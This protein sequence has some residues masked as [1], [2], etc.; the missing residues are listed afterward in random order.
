[1]HAQ[2]EPP[3]YE[4]LPDDLHGHPYV[5]LSAAQ[6]DVVVDYENLR[7]LAGQLPL[8]VPQRRVAAALGHPPEGV[9]HALQRTNGVGYLWATEFENVHQTWRY[10]E[11]SIE[12]DGETYDCVESYY[13]ARKSPFISTHPYEFDHAG[14]E[15]VKVNVMRCGLEQKLANDENVAALLRS[16]GKHPLLALKSDPFWGVHPRTGDGENML[17]KLLMELRGD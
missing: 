16:T 5:Y 12:V 2:S 15:Q 8:W 10:T 7:E 3:C 14:W 4:V 1:M 6:N 9:N 11:P 13:H 17:A